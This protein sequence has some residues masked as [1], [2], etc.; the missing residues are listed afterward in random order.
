MRCR[1]QGRRESPANI[2]TAFFNRGLVY[3]TKGQ[4][5]RALRDYDAAIQLR[6]KDSRAY[7]NRGIAHATK[8]QPDRASRIT[9]RSSACRPRGQRVLP[10]RRGLRRQGPGRARHPGLR[11]GNRAELAGRPG[12]KRPLLGPCCPWPAQA[13]VGRL[14]RSP[15]AAP[16]RR[17]HAQQPGLRLSEAETARLGDCRLRRGSQDQ[18]KEGRLAV[19]TRRR[20]AP[21]G[22]AAGGNADIAAAK[23]IW[24]GIA[25]D[26]TKW[27]V[28]GF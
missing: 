25:N 8:G 11:L 13:G 26:F 16:E 21:E 5:D 6:P 3:V 28:S 4:Y 17:R 23:A 24:P 19:R 14:Q 15:A 7:L 2:A 18:S 20:Q 9:I 1:D 10:P 27:R 22:H 12:L